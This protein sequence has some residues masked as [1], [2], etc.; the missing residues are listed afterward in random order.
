L[1][2]GLDPIHPDD[3]EGVKDAWAGAIERGEFHADYRIC[4][5]ADRR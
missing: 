4:H 5:H 2:G 3:R 1:G